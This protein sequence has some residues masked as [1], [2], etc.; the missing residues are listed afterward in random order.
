VS[1]IFNK[2]IDSYQKGLPFAVYR[3]PSSEMI[4]GFFQ[5]NDILYHTENFTESGFV[6]A[7]FTKR[8]K[9]VFIPVK[10]AEYIQDKVVVEKE[11]K[12]NMVFFS[13][14]I[15]KEAHLKLV[16]KAIEEI[17]RNHFQKVVVS[18]KE[19]V[20]LAEMN[21]LHIFHNLL[22]TYPTAMVSVF[23]HPKVGLWMGAT[24][25]TLLKTEGNSFETMSLAGTQLYQNSQKVV[26][27]KKEVDEQQ[28]VTHFIEDQLKYIATDLQIKMTDTVRAGDLLHLQTKFFGKFIQKN[29]SL[30]TFIKALH[31]TPAVCGLPRNETRNFILNN[32]TYPRTFYTGFLGEMNL[33]NK[34]ELFVNLRCMEITN[35][36]ATIFV[37]GG[38][39]KDSIPEKEWEETV[40]KT[41]TM[42]QVLS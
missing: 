5:N 30:K 18:R 11:F 21:I 13:D 15:L 2:I 36:I 39:T 34:S 26:W 3:K 33:N 31:P 7:P 10:E 14:A 28:L 25:E 6:F 24:P 42:K 17:D 1:L 32:E 40:A 16:E 22:K 8:E 12:L 41:S 23:Y 29:D 19:T 38:I 27:K 37:G 9:T 35:K 4:C 20:V